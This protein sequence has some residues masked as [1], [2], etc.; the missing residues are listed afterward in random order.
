MKTIEPGVSGTQGQAF[1]LGQVWT[2]FITEF[3]LPQSEQQ[4][5][6][7]LHE[8]QQR[9]GESSWEYNQKFK[10]SIGRLSHPIDEEHQREWYIQ[11][12]LPLTQIPLTQQ[13]IATFTDALEQSM[14]I[15]AMAGYPG[16]LRI[17]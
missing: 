16:S 15:E 1:T 7:K 10:D 6:S 4:T 9:E 11:G 13:W 17:T 3:K 5:L 14:K 2:R 8:I 12:L